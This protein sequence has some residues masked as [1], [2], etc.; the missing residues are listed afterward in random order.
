MHWM[1]PIE[2]LFGLCLS[3]QIYDSY[4]F[5]KQV[6]L[7]VTG[8]KKF[9]CGTVHSFFWC[10]FDDLMYETLQSKEVLFLFCHF[11]SIR[12]IV[13][14]IQTDFR[15]Y[16][17]IYH[18]YILVYTSTWYIWT[19]AK[20]KSVIFDDFYTKTSKKHLNCF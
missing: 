2:S 11:I 3:N 5:T 12:I 8:L 16:Y 4:I 15:T 10:D 6:T 9:D 7:S 14:L 20:K 18:S 19:L 1:S 13:T 17:I